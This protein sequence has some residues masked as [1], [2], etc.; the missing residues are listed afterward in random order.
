VLKIKIL[1]CMLLLNLFFT[2]L[3]EK[4]DLILNPY[5]ALSI[6]I[7]INKKRQDSSDHERETC[8]KYLEIT[9]KKLM[10]TIITKIIQSADSSGNLNICIINFI[11]ITLNYFKKT[12]SLL[13]N[14]LGL[15]ILAI[16]GPIQEIRSPE[17]HLA[18]AEGY[19]D[20]WSPNNRHPDCKKLCFKT[21]YWEFTCLI[22]A[23]PPT[24][25]AF[26]V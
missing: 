15:K 24:L 8:N 3:R 20:A 6:P 7:H 11:A 18:V 12:S 13:I 22:V 26:F 25:L 21:S 2:K 19:Q 17:Q 10:E 1:F 16:A 9:W 14:L 23:I 4:C 5:A